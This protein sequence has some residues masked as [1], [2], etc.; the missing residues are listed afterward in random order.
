MVLLEWKN[1]R[2]KTQITDFQLYIIIFI[3]V[4]YSKSNF[5][6]AYFIDFFKKKPLKLPFMI[7]KQGATANRN[8]LFVSSF[9]KF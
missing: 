6:Q 5:L 1:N 8:T 2:Q 9:R 3:S 4:F 7:K